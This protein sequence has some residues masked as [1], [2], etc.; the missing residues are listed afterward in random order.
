[1]KKLF[2][3][4]SLLFNLLSLLV[5]FIIGMYFAGWI[6]AGKDQ[7]LAGGAIVLGWGLLFGVIAFI[8]SFFATYHIAHKKLIVGNWVLFIALLFGYGIT[9]YRFKKRDKLQQ[10]RNKPYHKETPAKPKQKAESFALLT[11]F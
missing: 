2:K 3:P 1:M 8:A 6:E 10:E 9:H 5:F 4:A 7:G 11:I